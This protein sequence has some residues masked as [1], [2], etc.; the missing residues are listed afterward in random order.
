MQ[1]SP[2]EAIRMTPLRRCLLRLI[3]SAKAMLPTGVLFD[4]VLNYIEAWIRLGYAPYVRFPR[5][6]NEYILSSKRCFR[7]DIDL[8][9]RLTDKVLFKEWLQEQGYG[10]LVVPTLGIYDDVSEMRD[11]YF[12]RN[13]ILKPTHMSGPVLPLYASRKLDTRELSKLEEWIATDYYRKKRERTYAG[14]RKRLMCES[15]LLDSMGNIPTDYKIFVCSG[16]PFMIQVDINRFV[17]HT[18]QF[19][20]TDWELLGF[21]QRYPRNPT[22]IEKPRNLDDALDI[23]AILSGGFAICRVDLYLLPNTV[24]KAGEMTFF[25]HSGGERFYPMSADFELGEKISGLLDTR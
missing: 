13:T 22:P 3:F 19:Y 14:I 6:F 15:L 1:K 2:T 5:T 24:I 21:A 25:P 10:D 18:Q 17:N 23:S 8:A 20:S 11:V 12:E 4:D 7:G 9:R 16:I